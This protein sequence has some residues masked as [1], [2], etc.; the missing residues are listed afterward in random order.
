MGEEVWIAGEDHGEKANL[1]LTKKILAEVHTAVL[2]GGW[3]TE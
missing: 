1:S 2:P 3:S